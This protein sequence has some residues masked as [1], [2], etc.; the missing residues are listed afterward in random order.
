MPSDSQ[1]RSARQRE[2][3]EAILE[4]PFAPGP[5]ATNGTEQPP[6]EIP[7]RWHQGANNLAED[8]LLRWFSRLGA[9][10]STTSEFRPNPQEPIQDETRTW[11]FAG[12]TVSGDMSDSLVFLRS[13]EFTSSRYP[14]QCGLR[15]GNQIEDV[16]RLLGSPTE[17]SDIRPL[18]RYQFC[19]APDACRADEQIP[20]LDVLTVDFDAKEKTIRR[21]HVLY[22]RQH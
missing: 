22:P 12:A 13:I 9:R 4:S 20:G 15:V 21:V 3:L 17:S 10:A 16:V 14:L 11:Q 2:L 8:H 18:S 19:L 5:T 1:A 6:I 7:P